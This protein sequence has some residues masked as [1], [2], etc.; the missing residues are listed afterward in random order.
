MA[1]KVQNKTPFIALAFMLAL[2]SQINAQTTETAAEPPAQE[3]VQQAPQA[4][5]ATQPIQPVQPEQPVQPPV[6]QPEPPVPQPQPEQQTQLAVTSSCPAEPETPKRNEIKIDILYPMLSMIKFGYEF[7]LSHRQ[8]LAFTMRYDFTKKPEIQIQPLLSYKLYLA[9]QQ[10]GPWLFIEPDAGYT[11]G[12][13]DEK[14]YGSFTAG[15][16][17]GLKFYIP[18][19][20]VGFET[21]A[22]VN[23]VY[24][25]EKG[26]TWK[27][28]VPQYSVNLAWRF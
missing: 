18:N 24:G 16:S 9:K 17:G 14:S 4:E 15:I 1:K 13:V 28:W 6:A 25:K 10:V 7:S 19:T 8:A 11:Q 22:G 20:N 26:K 3:P 5:P 21:S 27:D 2:S 23:R 12:Y